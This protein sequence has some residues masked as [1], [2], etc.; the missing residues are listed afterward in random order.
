MLRE[1]PEQ[2]IHSGKIGAI[3]QIAPLLLDADQAGMS[4]LLQMK[5]QGVAGDAKLISQDAGGKAWKPGH[6]QRA[7][8]AQALGMGE[9][10]KSGNGLIF[11]HYS[12]IQRLL[13]LGFD[14]WPKYVTAA[15]SPLERRRIIPII[16]TRCW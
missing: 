8:C 9:A 3:D 6:D 14:N 16:S 15:P 11:I 1:I 5:G 10:C 4:E 13:N 2:P 7:E 12:M